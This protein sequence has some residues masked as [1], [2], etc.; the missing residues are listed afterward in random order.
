MASATGLR[1]RSPTWIEE[2]PSSSRVAG[3]ANVARRERPTL[4][5]FSRC[6][7]LVAV[8]GRA[9]DQLRPRDRGDGCCERPHRLTSPHMHVRTSTRGG[10][11]VLRDCSRARGSSRLTMKRSRLKT[12]ASRKHSKT[13]ARVEHPHCTIS[14]RRGRRVVVQGALCPDVTPDLDLEPGPHRSRARPSARASSFARATS[15]ILTDT[16]F[17]ALLSIADSLPGAITELHTSA[18]ELHSRPSG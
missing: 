7:P 6:E 18:R 11:G 14:R 15:A 10:Q 9:N 17:R 1:A 16:N 13:G 8:A 12:R 4:D 3:V 5:S 2:K